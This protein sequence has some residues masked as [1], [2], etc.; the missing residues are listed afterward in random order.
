MASLVHGKMKTYSA[1]YMTH[2]TAVWPVLLASWNCGVFCQACKY[3]KD[4]A[5]IGRPLTL[6]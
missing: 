2:M 3:Y 6:S 5:L 1:L 4:C